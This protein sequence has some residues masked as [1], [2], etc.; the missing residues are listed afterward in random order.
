[1]KLRRLRPA[2]VH[3]DLDEDI[4]RIRLGIFHEYVEVAVVV[5][6]AGIQKFVLELLRERRPFVSTRSR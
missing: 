2:V 3:R 6:D 4:L 5:E 1:M